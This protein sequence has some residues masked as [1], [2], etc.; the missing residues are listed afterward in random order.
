MF[1]AILIEIERFYEWKLMWKK[2]RYANEN[3]KANIPST[4]CDR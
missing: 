4:D 3:L 2:L 1:I